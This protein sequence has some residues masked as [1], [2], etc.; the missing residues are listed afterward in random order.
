MK[1]F[2]LLQL[3]S[4]QLLLLRQLRPRINHALPL[5]AL[6]C[7]C[8]RES[9]RVRVCVSAPGHVSWWVREREREKV[10]DQEQ[11]KEISATQWDVLLL[12]MTDFFPGRA[13]AR[14]C[15]TWISGPLCYTSFFSISE[16]F[17][18]RCGCVNQQKIDWIIAGV[19]LMQGGANE[20]FW[21]W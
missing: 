18:P 9:A 19:C 2:F 21:K 16:S 15:Y 10:P 6:L 4:F 5:I 7:N 11:I 17:P 13:S 20:D 8:L 12:Q 14:H 3:L 1:S